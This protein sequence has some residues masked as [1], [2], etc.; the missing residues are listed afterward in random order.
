MRST[1]AIVTA[2]EFAPDASPIICSLTAEEKLA[3]RRAVNGAHAQVY[4]TDE[5][6]VEYNAFNPELQLWVAACLY[7]GFARLSSFFL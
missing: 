7:W 5:S 1:V 4:S 2:R 6:P 3:Y